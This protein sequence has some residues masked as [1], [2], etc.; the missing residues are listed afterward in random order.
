[1][2]DPLFEHDAI[3]VLGTRVLAGGV[4]SRALVRRVSR[5][6]ELW[7]DGRAPRLILSGGVVRHPPAEAEVMRHLAREGGVPEDRLLLDPDAANTFENAVNATRIMQRE[8]WRKALVVTDGYHLPRALLVF[9]RLGLETVGV[10]AAPS[11]GAPGAY[12][13]VVRLR[14]V[15]AWPWYLWRVH[16]LDRRII[17]AIRSTGG[18]AG[19]SVSPTAGWRRDAS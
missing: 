5:A 13:A 18:A 11:P 12:E 1:M 16:V 17:A 4:P 2:P 10:A 9:R 15:A 19:V 7:Q 8:G 3:I 14:E 6:V